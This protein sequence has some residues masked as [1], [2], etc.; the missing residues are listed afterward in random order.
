MKGDKVV[1]DNL[2]TLL[3]NEFAA[4]NQYTLH[5]S[6]CESWGY[7]KLAKKYKLD[8]EEETEDA[9]KVVD[10]ILF[11]GGMPNVTNVPAIKPGESVKD[12]FELNFKLESQNIDDLNKGVEVCL[13]VKD[14][15]T[16]HMLEQIILHEQEHVDWYECQLQ[17]IGDMGID[18]YLASSI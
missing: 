7:K 18:N 6:M 11:L 4:I 10:R 2:N 13:G 12:Q 15:A 16:R 9:K 3:A 17:L 14:H 8:G 1:I 5:S